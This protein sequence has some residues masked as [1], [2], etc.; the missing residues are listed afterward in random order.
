MHA[1]ADIPT[2]DWNTGIDDKTVVACSAISMAQVSLRR[3]L[4]K[5]PAK[6]K[7][8]APDIVP[9]II[10]EYVVNIALKIYDAMK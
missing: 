1:E 8:D 2:S 10:I 5:P 4:R 7:P 9:I 3:W 6:K